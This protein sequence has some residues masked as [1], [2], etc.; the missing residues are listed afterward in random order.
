VLIVMMPVA[1]LIRLI[2]AK[3]CV[4]EQ[5]HADVMSNN[6]IKLAHPSP[7]ITQRLDFSWVTKVAFIWGLEASDISPSWLSNP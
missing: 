2:L 5:S 4:T 6:I 3:T 7:T 1:Q